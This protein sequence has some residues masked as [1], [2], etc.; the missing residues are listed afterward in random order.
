MQKLNQSIEKKAYRLA[1]LRIVSDLPLPG[2]PLCFDEHRVSAHDEIAIRRV[3]GAYPLS[4]V[5]MVFP[6]GQCNE[7]ELLLNVPEVGRFLIRYGNEI[8]V[9]QAPSANHNELCGYLLGM[10]FGVLCHQRG[11][12]P[13]HASAV[14]VSDGCVAFV[15]ESGAGKSTLV[16]ALAAREYEVIADDSCFL[17]VSNNGIVEGWPGVNQIR[18]WA[19]SL[20]ALAYDEAGFS[21]AGR[22]WNKYFIP[23]RPPR[24]P[25]G[26]RRL[27]R[28]YQLQVAPT[29]SPAKVTPLYGA[30][31]IEAIMQNVYR[32]SLAEY[33]GYK[34]H[35]FRLC[36]TA[37]DNVPVFRFS[38]PLGFDLLSKGV[39]LLEDHMRH[40]C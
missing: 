21:R 17:Q 37:A 5:R 27:R 19:D 20:T 12:T 35:V 39:D 38:R 28:V 24:N 10:V 15:G 40:P 36:A 9:E 22:I 2:V 13:L 30:A 18:L 11:I 25:A 31:A 26:A 6:K 23:V 8:L 7:N 1:G 16:A 4:T 14:D 3:R 33:M 32:L 29:G 34:P